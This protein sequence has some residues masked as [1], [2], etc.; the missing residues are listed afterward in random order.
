MIS[1][2]PLRLTRL[3]DGTNK[4]LICSRKPSPWPSIWEIAASLTL[5]DLASIALLL[6][7]ATCSTTHHYVEADLKLKQQTLE[8]LPP[9]QLKAG[10][11]KAT[12]RVLAFLEAL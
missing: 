11:F 9:L 10:A 8:K 7:H 3:S 5:I 12:D 4:G 6:G 2:I 1:G